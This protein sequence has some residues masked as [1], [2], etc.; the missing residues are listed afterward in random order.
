MSVIRFKPFRHYD[1]VFLDEIR[2]EGDHF[3]RE[4]VQPARK[5]T[6]QAIADVQ[7]AGYLNG[8]VDTSMGRWALS[9]PHADY[10]NLV[11]ANP[12]LNSP[13]KGIMNRA[14]RKF[15]AS[16]ESLPYRVTK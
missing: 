10:W 13:D 4:R 16:A 6:M 11:A 3:V 2:M 9:I 15:T 14:W 7:R 8:H 5:A 12:D 1:G